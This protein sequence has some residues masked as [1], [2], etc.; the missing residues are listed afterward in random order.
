MERPSRKRRFVS[1]DCEHQPEA[2]SWCGARIANCLFIAITPCGRASICLHCI[3]RYSVISRL[4][5]LAK[6]YSAPPERREQM[7][8]QMAAEIAVEPGTRAM[9]CLALMLCA[10][11]ARRASSVLA[12]FKA[13]GHEVDP[14]SGISL[15]PPKIAIADKM[16]QAMGP[17]LRR[18]CETVGMPVVIVGK[19]EWGT[20]HALVAEA[21][22]RDPLL[23][24]I[25]IVFV[26]DG[27]VPM[28]CQSPVVYAVESVEEVGG[29]AQV[30]RVGE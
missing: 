3:Q 27:F 21:T 17:L 26:R 22:A 18:G 12:G 11:L 10:R 29:D 19:S 30:Y 2:C 25:A 6:M 23:A 16:A 7:G 1:E 20:A 15:A 8:D 9:R 13:I 5:A 24:E 28:D 14:N 4:G